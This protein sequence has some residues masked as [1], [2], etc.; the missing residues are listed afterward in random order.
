MLLR[1]LANESPGCFKEVCRIFAKQDMA[2]IQNVYSKAWELGL[3]NEWFAREPG[4]SFNPRPAR[5]IQ[6]ALE[7]GARSVENLEQAILI[8]PLYLEH[9]D[10]SQSSLHFP[11]SPYAPY[12]L[13]WLR[14]FHLSIRFPAMTTDQQ[15]V[16]KLHTMVCDK[17]KQIL[18]DIAT[19]QTISPLFQQKLK[20]SLNRCLSQK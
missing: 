9:P 19:S 5:L 20:T 7:S 12:C 3:G 18:A 14:H 10:Q 6:L 16:K 17:T 4:V 13:D 2:K 11:L 1:I 8:A 15:F